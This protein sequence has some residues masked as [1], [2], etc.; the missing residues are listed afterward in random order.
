[1]AST[2][3][4]PTQKA[5]LDAHDDELLD[6][7]AEIPPPPSL[8]AEYALEEDTFDNWISNQTAHISKIGDD[9]KDRAAKIVNCENLP[10]GLKPSE[11]LEELKSILELKIKTLQELHQY[12]SDL[13]SDQIE[14]ESLEDENDV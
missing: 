2:I 6:D 8:P 4:I 7:H 11:A 13:L 14:F 3:T 5:S 1:M 9:I 12:V 10:D